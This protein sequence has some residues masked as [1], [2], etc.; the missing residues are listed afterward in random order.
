MVCL[1]A[2]LRGAMLL[3]PQ[4]V[5]CSPSS[6]SQGQRAS[7]PQE[8]DS[9]RTLE[10]NVLESKM[11]GPIFVLSVSS[12]QRQAAPSNLQFLS[13]LSFQTP[14]VKRPT[15]AVSHSVHINQAQWCTP[16]IPGLKR[17]RQ[18]DQEL[19][20]SLSYMRLCLTKEKEKEKAPHQPGSF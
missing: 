14:T 2:V 15:T 6:L 7:L 12:Q 9:L 3:L 11:R 16:V 17:L 18:E 8:K 4:A 1:P 5:C 13:S 19:M 10:V 20:T